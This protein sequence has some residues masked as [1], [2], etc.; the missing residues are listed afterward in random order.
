MGDHRSR[1]TDFGRKNASSDD[2]FVIFQPISLNETWS[3]GR[4]NQNLSQLKFWYAWATMG[5][6]SLILVKNP[7]SDDNFVTFGPMFMKFEV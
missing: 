4:I 1:L 3:V 7:F 2:N 6:A 5:H